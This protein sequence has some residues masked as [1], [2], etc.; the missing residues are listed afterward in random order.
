MFLHDD[1]EVHCC[2]PSLFQG[3]LFPVDDDDDPPGG[4]QSY[5]LDNLGGELESTFL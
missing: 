4:L 3:P 1:D 2:T 5:C